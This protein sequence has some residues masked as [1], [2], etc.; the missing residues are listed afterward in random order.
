MGKRHNKLTLIEREEIFGLLKQGKSIREIAHSLGRSPSSISS[1]TR[2]NGLTKESYCLSVAQVDRNV[3]A[4]LKGRKRKLKEAKEPLKLIKK[5]ILVNKWSPEQISGRLKIKFKKDS[6]KQVSHETIYK[7]IYSI[8]DSQERDSYI[9]SL[10]RRRKKRTHGIGSKK[11]RGPISDPVSIHER[12]SEVD[13]RIIPGHWEGDSI[14]GKDHQSAIGTLVERTSRY[15]IIVEY[16]NDKSAENVARAFAEAYKSIPD[17]LKKTLTFDR[18]AEMA[19]HKLFTQL[20]GIRVYFADPGCPGQ[21][22]T[23]E[24]TNGLIRQFFPKKTD[25]SRVSHEELK[26]VENLLNLRPRKILRFE[27]PAEA[28][29]RWGKGPEPPLINKHRLLSGEECGGD[30]VPR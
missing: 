2:R 29:G 16:G 15:T 11:Q 6:K 18:G 10:R 5:W 27:T 22:G 12:P 8:P 25:F 13:L 19:Q 26:E 30:L 1:E 20:T 9:K 17:C 28:L 21:R 7:Y 3:K 24:N 23:N 4:S 14:V